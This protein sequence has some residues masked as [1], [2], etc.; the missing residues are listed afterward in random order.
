MY[1]PWRRAHYVTT[2]TMA[3]TMMS[4]IETPTMIENHTLSTHSTATPATPHHRLHT[5]IDHRAMVAV[6]QPR[7]ECF[8]F[9][10]PPVPPQPFS[11]LLPSHG[12]A[13]DAHPQ[14]P[15]GT[16]QVDR[17]TSLLDF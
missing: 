4:M 14:Y 13:I 1:L 16:C 5:M 7:S 3:T 12:V 6:R 15:G 11:S 17:G 2:T 10:A 8:G 9:S